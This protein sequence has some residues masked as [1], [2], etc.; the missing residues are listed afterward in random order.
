VPAEVAAEQ[1]QGEPVAAAG[2]PIEQAARHE[3]T[4]QFVDVGHVA[5][6]DPQV[7]SREA[8]TG[9]ACHAEQEVLLGVRGG[10][11]AVLEER[12]I[13]L[14]EQGGLDPLEVGE[15][16]VWS[17]IW[18]ISDSPK[19]RP[20]PTSGMASASAAASSSRLSTTP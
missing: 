17:T 2:R 1:R 19:L 11:E 14:M 6:G 5:Q 10:Q 8:V 12:Q 3:A 9:A 13:E 4:K 20:V 7:G 18:P 16:A 15:P